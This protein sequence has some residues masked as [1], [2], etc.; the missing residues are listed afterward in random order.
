MKEKQLEK[1]LIK[2]IEDDELHQQWLYTLSYME[3]CGARKISRYESPHRVSL[4]VLKHAHEEARHA[5][6]FRRLIYKL[7]P[8]YRHRHFLLGGS[9][10]KNYLSKIELFICRKL[11]GKL[12]WTRYHY[13]VYLLTTLAIEKRAESLYPLYERLL[14]SAGLGI[15]ILS[16]IKEEDGH[17]EFIQEQISQQ[18]I[19]DQGLVRELLIFEQNQFEEL[20]LRVEQDIVSL[21]KLNLGAITGTADAKVMSVS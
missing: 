5:Y 12:E 17:L 3:N 14:H 9:L 7:N 19:L 8:H 18:K 15:S 20:I 16:V 13:F 4:D 21:D 6:F 11:K 1:I 2:I 10:S